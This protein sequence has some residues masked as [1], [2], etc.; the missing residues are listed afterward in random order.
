MDDHQWDQWG[1]VMT[2]AECLRTRSG[3]A[4]RLFLQLLPAG[5]PAP[6]RGK[7]W[8]ELCGAAD[9]AL[10]G[11]WSARPGGYSYVQL[12]A[13]R[14]P[15][16]D[17][18]LKDVPRTLPKHPQF[19]KRSDRGARGQAALFN[20]V[21]AFSLHDDE[22]GYCQGIT[23]LAAMLLLSNSMDEEA[24][25][26]TL[27]A[28]MSAEHYGPLRRQF[29]PGMPMLQLR[30]W[31]LERLLHRHL[32]RFS[33]H[34]STLGVLPTTF[35]SEWFLTLFAQGDWP[36]EWVARVWDLFL[37]HGVTAIFAIALAVCSTAESQCCASEPASSNAAEVETRESAAG[38]SSVRG[39]GD[40][41]GGAIC[42]RRWDFDRTVTL[43]RHG[44]ASQCCMQERSPGPH[45]DVGE[46]QPTDSARADHSDGTLDA[47]LGS[48]GPE[49]HITP[50]GLCLLSSAVSLMPRLSLQKHLT[51]LEKE[52]ACSIDIPSTSQSQRRA[53]ASMQLQGGDSGCTST[54]MRQRAA[55]STAAGM[56]PAVTGNC[57]GLATYTY[58]YSHYGVAAAA[59][60]AAADAH[61]T[62]RDRNK[63][64][65]GGS[66]GSVGG[67]PGAHTAQV[68]ATTTAAVRRRIV[69]VKRE[70]ARSER[71]KQQLMLEIADAQ[72]ETLELRTDRLPA[73]R[74][75]VRALKSHDVAPTMQPAQRRPPPT[76]PRP[77]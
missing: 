2:G 31:Q 53:D 73:L 71:R 64:N 45:P 26:S 12:A 67:Y 24:A 7:V 39:K 37:V 36:T 40:G 30:I 51:K 6:L 44:I 69:E 17:Q 33:S 68:T 54:A 10:G 9:S 23:S 62:G 41:A 29:V 34:L 21:R 76:P 70:L 55:T 47:R 60:A 32:P 1:A 14:S 77:W 61:G 27:C 75:E 25:F 4:W 74:Y 20:V 18:I 38:S 48:S 16:E 49:P 43:L 3:R 52:Y 46:L 72:A 22:V 8:Q 63:S 65:D 50:V 13:Q 57:A 5:I 59:A 42:K 11:A 58:T 56:A 19:A 66:N 15:A 28:L 35:A